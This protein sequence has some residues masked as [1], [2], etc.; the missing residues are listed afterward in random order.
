MFS[1]GPGISAA[2]RRI[3]FGGKAF[4]THGPAVLPGAT[5]LV[6]RLY[7]TLFSCLYYKRI[8][9]SVNVFAAFRR[10]FVAFVRIVCPDGALFCTGCRKKTDKKR[11]AADR[12]C[13]NMQ[14]A[15]EDP[16]I[17]PRAVPLRF[18]PSSG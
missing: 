4:R 15:G 7:H 13:M 9:P 12:D 6:P 14:K 5:D 3:P 11:P 16:E 1:D 2:G 17:L 18:Q 8:S 10:I